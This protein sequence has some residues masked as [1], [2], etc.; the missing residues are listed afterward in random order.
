[1]SPQQ[2]EWFNPTVQCIC[3]GA[4]VQYRQRIGGARTG[5]PPFGGLHVQPHPCR[6]HRTGGFGQRAGVGGRLERLVSGDGIGGGGIGSG[7][8]GV[9]GYG[10]HRGLL[11]CE[12]AGHAGQRERPGSRQ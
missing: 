11:D 6:G 3:V 9:E 5:A 4:G 2:P 12:S 10:S 1:M 8:T 7:G